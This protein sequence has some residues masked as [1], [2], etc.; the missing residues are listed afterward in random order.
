MARPVAVL[1]F[2][3]ML[4]T[5]W[6]SPAAGQYTITGSKNS[7]L[8]VYLSAG[9]ILSL[10][11]RTTLTLGAT[12]TD[13][14][15]VEPLASLA[16]GYAL[17]RGWTATFTASSGGIGG[18]YRVDRLP[19][20]SVAKGDRVPGTSLSYGI[21]LGAGNYTVRPNG[22]TGYRIHGVAQLNTPAYPLGRIVSASAGLGYR[23]YVYAST[24]HGAGWGTVAITIAPAPAVSVTLS[25]LRQIPSGTSPLLFDGMGAESTL[26]GG[27]TLRPVPGLTVSHSQSYSYLSNAISAR[28]YGLSVAVPGGPVISVSWDD[29]PQTASLS[30]RW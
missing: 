9:R 6:V 11:P 2:A 23:Q 12:Y 26:T 4:V 1:V 22:L 13:T 8:G 15:G 27:I 21:E 30:F 25:Y 5:L 29:V 24:Q 16:L 18:D 19:E 3:A 14:L 20:V 10:A 17:P 7:I 28:V